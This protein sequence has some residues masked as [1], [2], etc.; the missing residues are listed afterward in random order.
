MTTYFCVHILAMLPIN[1]S[2]FERKGVTAPVSQ[3]GIAKLRHVCGA[4]A[5]VG[6]WA[7][8]SLSSK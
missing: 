3:I 1:V 5:K 4:L 2:F 8:H 7:E 6:S